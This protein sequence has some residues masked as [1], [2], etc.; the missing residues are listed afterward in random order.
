MTGVAGVAGIGDLSHGRATL[1][2]IMGSPPMVWMYS[3]TLG[4]QLLA[5]LMKPF[6]PMFTR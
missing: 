3:A 1:K 2:G 5:F 6:L 4:S